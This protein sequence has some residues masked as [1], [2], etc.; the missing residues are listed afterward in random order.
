MH[1]LDLA[2]LQARVLAAVR[3]AG[4]KILKIYA[5]DFSV[6]RKGDRSPLTAADTAAH[7]CLKEA[8]WSLPAQFPILSEEDEAAPYQERR[9]WSTY[10]L[11]DPLDGT[12]EFI[13]R[14][15]EFTV[16]VALI[17]HHEPV[18]GVVHVP[19]QDTTYYAA[20]GLGAFKQVGEAAPQ[21]I[22][23]RKPAP[24]KLVIVGSRS[25]QTPAFKAYLQKLDG[26]YELISIGSSLKFCLVAEGRADLYPRLGP[27]SEWDTAAAQCVVVE[28]GGYVVDLAGKPLR[29]NTK[30]SILNPYFLVY[31]DDSRNFLAYLPEEL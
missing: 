18:L 31:A 10:W 21:A 26:A 29:Y 2:D 8:L 17:H 3:R 16:N 15:G 22:R 20:T 24:E 7:R 11:L 27:T 23:V 19:V 12:K 25:H 28:A 30:D 5:S 4:H 14:N 9:K 13:N 1:G 6:Y